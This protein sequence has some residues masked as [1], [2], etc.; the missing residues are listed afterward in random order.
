MCA[1]LVE[2][3]GVSEF[4]WMSVLLCLGSIVSFESS[5]TSGSY[6][7]STSFSRQIPEPRGEG[8][9]GDMPFKTDSQVSHSLSTVHLWVLVV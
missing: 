6:N 3:A 8:F 5:N 9:D 4:M 2:A 7:L 1:D